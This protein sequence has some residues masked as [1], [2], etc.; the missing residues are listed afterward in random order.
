MPAEA[1]ARARKL[2]SGR[3]QLRYTVDGQVRSGGA[4][5]SR[6]EALNH[7]RDVIEPELDGSGPVR[8]DVTLQD[9]ADT[10][11]QRHGAIAKPV[12]VAT[13]RARLVRPLD[14]FGTTRVVELERMA[15]EI[16]GFAAALPER[17]RYSIMSAFRQTCAAGIR[18][19]YMSRT[20]PRRR[21][22]TRHLLPA[23]SA[24]SRP[25]S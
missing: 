18:Y 7:Y 11:L 1:R 24:S 15:D 4:F 3:W 17:F 20:R 16:A 10:F 22:E 2:P 9:L 13:L 21:G 19:G 12:T 14:T 5:N 6:T 8:R 25:P 23:P